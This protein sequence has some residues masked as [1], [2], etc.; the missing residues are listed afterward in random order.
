M[1]YE[2]KENN[3]TDRRTLGVNVACFNGAFGGD[4]EDG[5]ATD[6]LAKGLKGLGIRAEPIEWEPKY[7]IRL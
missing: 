3:K 5:Y 1:L 7:R 4:G 6:G 2:V